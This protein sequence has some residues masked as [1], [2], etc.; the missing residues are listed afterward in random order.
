MKLKKNFVVYNMADE[1]ML[2]PTGE[3]MSSFGGAVILNEV[4]AFL[5]GQM[6]DEH[7]DER[8]LVEALLSEYEVDEDTAIK[9][10][11]AAVASMKE[12]GVLED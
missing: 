12:S 8:E 2:I 6:K 3:Q 11:A 10:V 7:K 5:I 4:S 9:D 1:Y